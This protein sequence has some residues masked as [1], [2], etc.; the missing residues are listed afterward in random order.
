MAIA[1]D[2]TITKQIVDGSGTSFNASFGTAPAAGSLVVVYLVTWPNDISIDTIDDNQGNGNYTILK[3]TAAGQQQAVIAYKE[4]VASSGTFTISVNGV[5]S[6]SYV[7]WGASS[8]TGIATASSLD[9]QGGS[10]Q[11]TPGPAD[12]SASTA[13]TTAQNDELVIAVAG[14]SDDDI[15]NGLGAAATTG[16]TNLLL[17]LNFQSHAAGSADYKIVS[18]TGVQSANWTSDNDSGGDHGWTTKIATFKAVAAA[19][20]GYSEPKTQI[21]IL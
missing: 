3:S 5:G 17:E 12:P 16:Y 9:Q 6:G 19:P 2:R 1:L 13:G 11:G 10:S 8:F 20:A 21:I 7:V 18:S 15:N 4:N 14:V